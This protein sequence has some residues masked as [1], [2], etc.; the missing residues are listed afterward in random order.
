MRSRAF[1]LW[2]LVQFYERVGL[3]PDLRFELEK[4]YK[5]RFEN[6]ASQKAQE[7]G[8]TRRRILEDDRSWAVGQSEALQ[9]ESW[10]YKGQKKL[11]SD[12]SRH[13]RTVLP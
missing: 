5:Y 13:G 3:E 2:R 6:Y 7:V 8:V 12:G 9:G 4:L 11:H 1:F 10:G